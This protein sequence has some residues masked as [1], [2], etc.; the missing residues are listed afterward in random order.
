MSRGK[1][2]HG[3]AMSCNNFLDANS[4]PRTGEGSLTQTAVA[5][6]KT[7]QSPWLCVGR[8]AG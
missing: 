4:P 2:L 5:I 6:I 8:N 1:I 3:K 7:Q